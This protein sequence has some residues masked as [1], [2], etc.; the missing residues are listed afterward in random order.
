VTQSTPAAGRQ[1]ASAAAQALPPEAKP[2]RGPEHDKLAVFLGDWRGQGT[3]GGGS[4][5]TT[6]ESYDWIEGKFFLL[7]RFDQ[8]VGEAR[9]VGVATIGYD[10]QDRTYRMQM[11]DNL[12]YARTYEVR[13]DGR[14]VWRFLGERERAT[15]TFQGD[16]LNV[17]W[18]HRPE[19]LEW[20]P[21]CELNSVNERRGA[22]H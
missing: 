21:L 8:K 18:E 20:K 3:G 11:A 6:L 16:R 12:G 2:Q 1:D 15:L 13:D 7:S 10:P 22:V 4:P 14:G 5:M 19:G 17:R 9:H